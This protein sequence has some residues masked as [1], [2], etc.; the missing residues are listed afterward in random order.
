M[1][2]TPQSGYDRGHLAC[3]ANHRSSAETFKDTFSLANISPQVGRGFNRHYWAQLE[4]WIRNIGKKYDEIVVVSGPLFLGK[5]EIA[6][7][8]VEQGEG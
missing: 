8:S 2:T 1:P 6:E 5:E 3:A 7:E 4:M